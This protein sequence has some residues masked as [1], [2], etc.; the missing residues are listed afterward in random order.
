MYLLHRSLFIALHLFLVHSLP[1]CLIFYLFFYFSI[2]F[3]HCSPFIYISHC[4]APSFCLQCSPLISLPFSTASSTPPLLY[5]LSSIP[6]LIPSFSNVSST[7]P[8]LYTTYPLFLIAPL[9]LYCI[10]LQYQPFTVL[11][12][13]L[14][15]SVT[16]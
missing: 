3:Y 7:P 2:F 9:F 12:V 10:N 4:T 13:I 5:H 1:Y 6:S 16:L 11:T 14:Y 15:F 8:L